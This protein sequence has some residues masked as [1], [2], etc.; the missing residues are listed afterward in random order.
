MSDGRLN[1]NVTI[2]FKITVALI[3]HCE[4]TMKIDRINANLVLTVIN[5]LLQT[6][7][8]MVFYATTRSEKYF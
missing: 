4:G 6:L 2:I 8:V 5:E 1:I 3:H 7:V